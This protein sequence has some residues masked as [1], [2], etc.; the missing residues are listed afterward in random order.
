MKRCDRYIMSAQPLST[1]DE[2]Q[3]WL[4]AYAL[5]EAE[6]DVAARAHLDA[7]PRC[8]GDMRE[9]RRVAALLPFA[10]PVA[11]PAPELRDRIVGAVAR[12]ASG[13]R[14]N[15]RPA[16]PDRAAPRPWRFFARPAW[17]TAAFAALSV[18]LLIWSF[19]LLNQVNSQA[20][21]LAFHRRSWQT[22]IAML[23]DSSIR[24]YAMAGGQSSGHVWALPQGQDV[25]F[26]AQGLPAVAQGQVL[27]LWVGRPGREL[28]GGTFVARDGAVWVLFRTDEPLSSYQTVFVT[29]E[30]SG[31]SLAPTGPRV[32]SGSLAV[33]SAPG[34]ADRQEILRLVGDAPQGQL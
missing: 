6:E 8:Q 12:A 16:R 28:S 21:E 34:L 33:A 20:E 4:A 2:I 32:L 19:V 7:C 23:N 22:M 3:A 25:C 10:A 14:E 27:Q 13:A 29:I 31:G 1:C 11:A 5:G 24:W 30:P 17:P 18:A 15:P 26:V 9:Y